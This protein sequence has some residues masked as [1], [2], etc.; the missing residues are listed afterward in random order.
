M[1]GLKNVWHGVLS[2]AFEASHHIA[3]SNTKP[4]AFDPDQLCSPAPATIVAAMSTDGHRP[5]NEAEQPLC[6]AIL[7]SHQAGL[8]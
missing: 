4:S 6:A 3:S 5:P 1:Q 2:P 7:R 8:Q